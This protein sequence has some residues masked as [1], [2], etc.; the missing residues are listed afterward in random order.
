MRPT[1][2][3]TLLALSIPFLVEA[4]TTSPVVETL[5]KTRAAEVV[6]LNPEYLAYQPAKIDADTKVPLVIYLHGAGGTGSDIR[7]ITGQS[8]RLVEAIGQFDKGPCLVVAPQCRRE[9]EKSDL[10]GIWEP[11]D[12]DLFL[13]HLLD[14]HDFI[15]PDRVYLTGNS[16]GGYGSWV[17]GGHSPQHFAAIAPM[18][19]GIGRGGPKDV[20]PDIEKWA[21]NLAK[22]PVW[23][24][25]GAQDKVVPADRSERMIAAIKKAGGTKARILVYP[26]E[27]HGA[28][29]RA[30]ES[31]EYFDWLFSQKRSVESARPEADGL[32][33]EVTDFNAADVSFQREAELPDLEAPYLSVDPTDM[34]DGIAVAA[35]TEEFGCRD[36]ILTF[37][38]E[39]AAGNHGEI[40]SFLLMRDGKLI[41]ESY[42]RR[43]RANYPHYQMSIT[44]SYTAMALGRA[45]Q[46]GHLTMSDLDKPVV[47]FLDQIDRGKLVDGATAITLAEAMN[48]RSGI[49]IDPAKAK[50]LMRNPGTLKSQRQI[51]AYLENS[52]PIPPAP[53]EF[54]YQ[55]SDPSMTMQVIES[56]VPGSAREFITT[57]LLGKMGIA[58]FAWQDDVSGLPKSA[59]GSSMRSRDMIK[60]GMLVMNGG[61]WNGEQLV[62]TE[63]VERAT[64]PLH[65]NSRRTSYGFF[66]WRH[67]ME[68][69]DRTVDCIS[70]RGAGGQFILMFPE[71]DLIAVITA[72]NKGM[73]N[74]L[75]TFPERV[76][77]GFLKKQ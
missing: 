23:A 39:I 50:E 16:M 42:F 34:D 5:D 56:V 47:D 25:A 9:S 72:H 10:K 22:V 11:T 73:G 66:W 49:R 18:V 64:S 36:A 6:F 54:K 63:F 48:M 27:G 44:K 55:G 37:A 3:F 70:G 24:F 15:D 13:E 52:A 58:N 35:F 60:W 75:K 69:G 74:L 57:E 26:D 38:D 4:Q 62:P 17:W 14:T 61:K 40:D 59:A 7:K 32:A 20:S 8:R 19:G 77:P 65:T 45:I 28:S 2:L 1:I 68:L 33:P 76:L 71:L 43:G 29:R 41:F 30:Y 46:V 31:E 51:Q 67:E 53:R 21:V 12:L